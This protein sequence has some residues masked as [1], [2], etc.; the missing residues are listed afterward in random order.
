[1][2]PVTGE[3]CAARPAPKVLICLSMMPNN[4]VRGEYVRPNCIQE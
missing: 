1:M 2:R 4:R 3:T